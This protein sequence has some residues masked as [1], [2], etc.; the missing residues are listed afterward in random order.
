MQ[1][2]TG[3]NND[4][5]CTQKKLSISTRLSLDS[6][7]KLITIISS[8]IQHIIYLFIFTKTDEVSYYCYPWSGRGVPI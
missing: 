4:T 6:Q 3:V 1:I 8:T 2:T 7:I 5:F